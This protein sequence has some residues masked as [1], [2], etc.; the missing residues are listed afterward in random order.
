LAFLCIGADGSTWVKGGTTTAKTGDRMTITEW[1]CSLR[2][3][4]KC[5]ALVRVEQKGNSDVTQLK[6]A[7]PHAHIFENDTSA[8]LPTRVKQLC[9]PFLNQK[10][11]RCQKVFTAL[12]EGGVDIVNDFKATQK[13]KDQ[14]MTF[15]RRERVKRNDG[16]FGTTY[17]ALTTFADDHR[18][19]Y[20]VSREAPFFGAQNR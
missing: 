9:I 1:R 15:I 10:G 14:V 20:S 19:S 17:G 12:Q 6:M 8:C 18:L 2:K 16:S 13:H 4:L 7:R 3:K 11:A 5:V